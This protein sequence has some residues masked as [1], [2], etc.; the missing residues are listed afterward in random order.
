MKALI[1]ILIVISIFLYILTVQKL[2]NLGVLKAQGKLIEK[3]YKSLIEMHDK[4]EV[5]E[6]I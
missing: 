6:K 3:I 5:E 4:K 1:I 2:P